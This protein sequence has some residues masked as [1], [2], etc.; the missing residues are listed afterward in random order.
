M[1][2]LLIM[3]HSKS[4]WKNA[5][6]ADMD[7]PLNERGKRDAQWTGQQLKK[8]RENPDLIL[9]SPAKR[10]RSTAKRIA[11]EL[12]YPTDSIQTDDRIYQNKLAMLLSVL[13]E[14]DDQRQ[15]VMLIGHN[16]SIT[17]L[18]GFLK[19]ENIEDAPTSAVAA[20]ELDID[21]WSQLEKARLSTIIYLYPGKTDDN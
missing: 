21:K 11:G 8:R 19:R 12:E 13:K 6:L 17:E 4:S 2:R 1:K 3:R 20:C 14:L 15:S 7:R 18:I 10:T 5:H 16:P 9:C